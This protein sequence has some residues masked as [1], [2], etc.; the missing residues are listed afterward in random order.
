MSDVNQYTMVGRLVRDPLVKTGDNA[1]FALFTLASNHRYKD[2]Q[3]NQQMDVAFVAC[4]VFGQWVEAIR[5]SKKGDM[6]MVTG[7]F[8]TETW[9]QNSEQRQQLTLLCGS[10]HAVVTGEAKKENN[11]TEIHAEITEDSIPF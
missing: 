8:R 1:N 6:F 4:K 11:Q 9:G 7:R 5:G 3:G 10:I 2:R